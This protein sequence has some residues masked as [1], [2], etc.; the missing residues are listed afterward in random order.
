MKL[1]CTNLVYEDILKLFSDNEIYYVKDYIDTDSALEL[2]TYGDYITNK[3]QFDNYDMELLLKNITSNSNAFG[4]I[5]L[6]EW[7]FFYFPE[8]LEYYNKTINTIMIQDEFIPVTW[9]F[10]IAIMVLIIFMM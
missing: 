9:R 5:L 1:I 8:Y 4:R 7:F 2:K 3:S 10:Y 6:H